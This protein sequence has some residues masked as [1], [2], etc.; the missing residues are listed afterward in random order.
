[1]GYGLDRSSIPSKGKNTV[2]HSTASRSALG[3]TQPPTR[4]VTEALSPEVKW[5]GRENSHSPPSSDEIKNGGPIP[6][7]PHT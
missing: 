4:W 2:I 1:M 6:P 7:L 3:P 5:P